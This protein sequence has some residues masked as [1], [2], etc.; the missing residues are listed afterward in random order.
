MSD[1]FT[2]EIVIGIDTHKYVH[3]ADPVRRP[4]I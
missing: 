1:A 2:A 4:M 3:A